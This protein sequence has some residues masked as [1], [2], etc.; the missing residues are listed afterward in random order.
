M[1]L[2]NSHW[3]RLIYV[4]LA[5]VSLIVTSLIVSQPLPELYF[6]AQALVSKLLFAAICALGII[7]GI[8]P[9]WCSVGSRSERR[10]GEAVA[11][12]HPDCGHFPGHTIMLGARVFCAGCSGLVLG[13]VFALLGLLSGYY[14]LGIDVGFWFGALIVGLGLAQHYI[15]LGSGWVHFCLNFLFVLGVWFMF[16]A[17]QLMGLSF[18]VSSYF[19]SVTVFWIYARIR[20]S[21]WTHVGVC[22]GCDELCSIRFE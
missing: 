5:E 11:G 16:E 3:D 12:H 4:L 21:Q 17:I 20:A 10:S 14:P 13:A 18:I 2:K 8:A 7:A 9:N 22:R 6:S 15:D 19:L 1:Q